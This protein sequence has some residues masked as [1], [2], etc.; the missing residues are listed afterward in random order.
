[1]VSNEYAI[2]LLQNIVNKRSG[3]KKVV[4]S[5][6]F[7]TNNIPPIEEWMCY[8]DIF[9]LLTNEE[10]LDVD[11]LDKNLV[12]LKEFC[13]I[14]THPKTAFFE[15]LYEKFTEHRNHPNLKQLMFELIRTKD[16]E[17]LL[18]KEVLC[19]EYFSKGK[20]DGEH[21]GPEQV[22]TDIPETSKDD[23][24][25]NDHEIIEKENNVGELLIKKTTELC[26][27]KS[28]MQDNS[29]TPITQSDSR[30]SISGQTEGIPDTRKG[31]SFHGNR[32]SSPENEPIRD[33]ADTKN[34]AKNVKSFEN[35]KSEKVEN[36]KE[37]NTICDAENDDT[38]DAGVTCLNVAND[39]TEEID[40]EKITDKSLG[41]DG[42]KVTDDSDD[43]GFV[44]V[45]Y[46]DLE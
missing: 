37:Q 27:S 9:Y 41:G 6:L 46:K 43:D 29:C 32:N 39:D 14:Y 35:P 25:I 2:Y 16:E 1:M 13:D 18:Q 15:L 22:E 44:R 10:K 19:L 17:R 5:Y 24:R 40:E 42:Q 28:V 31:S 38:V 26:I 11:E 33:T 36:G 21:S 3:W 45:E 20:L 23:K 12:E 4:G 34:G 7:R 30:E 8:V